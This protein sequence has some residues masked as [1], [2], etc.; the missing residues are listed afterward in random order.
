M[1][2]RFSEIIEINPRESIPKGKVC[3]K[4]AMQNLLE[5]TREIQ[6][7]TEEEFKGGS[8]FRQ[9]DTLFARITPCL[10]NG[11]IAQVNILDEG[12]VAFGSTEFLVFRAKKNITLPDYV[13]H[14]SK[15]NYV[16]EMAIKSMTGTSGRQRVQN[17]IFD[18]ILINLPSI[19]EQ[20]VIVYIL[21]AFDQ[22]I[23]I[24]NKIIANLEEHAQAIFKAWFVDFEPFQDGDFVESELGPIPKG[25]EVKP[26]DKIANYKNG[27]AMQ[28]YPPE[29][30]LE[31]LPVL[32]IQELRKN[33]TDNS[34]DRCSSNIPDDVKVYD[35]D[36]IFSWS[37]TLFV[38]IWTGGDAGLN[39]H[40][41]KVTSEKYDK[42]FYYLWTLNYLER[43]QNIARDKATTMGHIKRSHL[44]EALIVIPDTVTYEKITQIMNPMIESLVNLGVQ[45]RKLAQL[46]DALL[47][48]LMSGEIDVS[49]LSIDT[50]EENHG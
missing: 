4:I 1:E 9:G 50:E 44:K 23:D 8:K 48:K 33:S 6:G 29:S 11:N 41:F 16:R 47:P 22:K 32:K 26:L 17:A 20:R 30:Q 46:R 38:K 21:N 28:K 40:L 35:G 10:E 37:A 5:N 7:Y 3:K 39:Q 45:N 14:L 13:Y 36:V 31:S 12:E 34:S 24:N 42:W 49:K 25:W 18:E 43:F 2:Y 27:L 15:W 19:E